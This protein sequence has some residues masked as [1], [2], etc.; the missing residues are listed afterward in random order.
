MTAEQVGQVLLRQFGARREGT[1]FQ[2]PSDA[3]V[4]L[5][6]ALEGETLTVQRVARVD[7]GGD[8]VLTVETHKGEQ[9]A[10]DAQTVRALKNE[11]SEAARKSGSAGFRG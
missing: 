2:V 10:F 11:R 9:F 4:S 6:V 8:P 1:V 5:L 3:D 7:I